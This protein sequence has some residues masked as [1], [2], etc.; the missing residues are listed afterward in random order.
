MLA[1]KF[2]IVSYSVG[3]EPRQP[4]VHSWISRP[5]CL[6]RVRLA[7]VSGAFVVV[8]IRVIVNIKSGGNHHGHDNEL[9]HEL[10][11]STDAGSMAGANWGRG[12][13][14]CDFDFNIIADCR[15]KKKK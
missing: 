11:Q 1:Q 14:C 5:N 8:N 4:R 6:Q 15:L 9:Q 13:D 2:S 10:W 7:G 3:W 12:E